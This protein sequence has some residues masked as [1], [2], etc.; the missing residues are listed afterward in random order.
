[1][2]KLVKIEGSGTNQPE[3]IKLR[4][5]DNMVY[6]ANCAYVMADGILYP[7]DS[8]GYPTHIAV[9]N[10][11]TEEKDSVTC[12]RIQ[13]NMIF[14]TTVNGDLANGCVNS[15]YAMDIDDTGACVGITSSLTNGKITLYDTNGAEKT[16]DTVY[17]RIEKQ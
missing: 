14:E 7:L 9:E 8:E 4:T 10:A 12:Y 17:V 13:D 6:K 2:L 11:R 1:M 3:P 15:K 5:A 16:G